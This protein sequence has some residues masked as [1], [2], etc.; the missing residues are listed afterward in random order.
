MKN[1]YLI[2]NAHLDPVWMWEKDEGI[3]EV[4]STYRVAADFCEEYED[5]VFNHNE[6]V[7]YEWVEEYDLDL[8][9]RIQKLVKEGRWKIIGGF[10]LQPD[11]NMPSGEGIVRQA[12][13]GRKYFDEKF[14]CRP[15]TAIN[16]DSFGHSRG[17]VQIFSKAGYDSYIV[18]RPLDDKCPL[19]AEDFIWK[20]YDG[21][22][23]M[24]HRGYNS[25]ES[26]RGNADEKIQG[27]LD[28]FPDKEVGLVLWGIGNH[29]GGPSR[30]DYERISQLG[31]KVSPQWT[32]THSYPEA[33]FEELLAVKGKENIPVV[34]R[35]L[36][37][38][39]V[40][41]YTSQIRIKQKYRQLENMLFKVEKMM[42][43]AALNGLCEYPQEQLEEAQKDMLFTQFHDILP[44]SSIASAEEAAIRQLDHGLEIVEKLKIKAFLMLMK[45]EEK[46]EDGVIP[47]F[48]Y[49][50]HPM[51]VNTL[52]ECE[53]NLPD[54]NI[55]RTKWSFPRVYQNGQPIP[56][57]V[58]HEESNFNVDWRKR[59]VFSAE[60]APSSL[61]RFECKVE[62]WDMEPEKQLC[63]T[64]DCICF[65]TEDL[66]VE[67]NCRTGAIDRY[68]VKGKDYLKPGTCIPMVMKDDY[69]S[70]GNTCKEYRDLEGCFRLMDPEEGTE[71]SGIE[72]GHI[73]DSVRIIEDGEIRSMIEAVLKYNHSVM[74]IR[75]YLPKKGTEV[76]VA[77]KV[78][79]GEKMKMLKFP[80]KTCFE[81]SK[82]I[83][84]VMYGRDELPN[85]GMEVVSQRFS[86]VVSEK[87][88]AAFTIINNGT[89]G[90]DCK[91]GEARIS[92]L[93][94]PGYSAGCSDFSKRKPE[95][96]EQER[97]NVFMDQGERE[98]TF[99]LNAGTV[100]E[101]MYAVESE[102]ALHNETP[103]AL[104]CFPGGKQKDGIR[105]LVALDNE[106]I[107]LTTFKKGMESDQYILRLFEPTGE[108]RNCTITLPFAGIS[109]E[110]EISGF[111][112]QTWGY[113]AAANKLTQISLLETEG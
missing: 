95:V 7:L 112:I 16:F 104:S 15:R 51:K 88:D 100:T 59:V 81:D 18:C 9:K 32:M 46:A 29:G 26:H 21:S 78:N 109:K 35:P 68:A 98:F 19:P 71:Y 70:W 64:E 39:S 8:F 85:D 99:W 83:G 14:G 65:H 13:V 27:Y 101:R 76:K 49:N 42:S 97:C 38:H 36:H 60:L 2:C 24:C 91:D 3:A 108:K 52:I 10:Y 72:R 58:E 17:L 105:Q 86:A 31:R 57:Q 94:S 30:I 62:S 77:V 1:L 37:Y 48:V 54:Q 79:W 28:T 66:D 20:G 90:S 107:Q 6:S 40:G 11:C 80:V 53:F 41:C 55:D 73:I 82:Y 102:A 84:Q 113:D 50:P 45:G 89:Y 34:A 111:E 22:E 56:C 96:M 69:D 103:F 5:F 33:Y 75:Y 25:Y 12:L 87:D 23:I 74:C 63:K 106:A 110:I 93:R 92:M 4:L 44:G 67:I 43:C 61:N 47:V